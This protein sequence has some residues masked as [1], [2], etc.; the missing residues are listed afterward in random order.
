MSG[1]DSLQRMVLT[2]WMYDRVP[3]VGGGGG[4]RCPPGE[5]DTTPDYDDLATGRGSKSRKG[6]DQSTKNVMT[7][8]LEQ[9]HTCGYCGVG[10]LKL[11]VVCPG[12]GPCAMIRYCS[13]ECLL[14]DTTHQAFVCSNPE[15]VEIFPYHI[16]LRELPS[17]YRRLLPAIP[18]PLNAS[19]AL[20]RQRAFVS[21]LTDATAWLYPLITAH[22]KVHK[23]CTVISRH[24]KKLT[25]ADWAVF[26]EKPTCGSLVHPL[27]VVT[28]PTT[29]GW[30]ACFR[31]LRNAAMYTQDS[32]LVE[33]LA[34]WILDMVLRSAPPA[35]RERWG[36]LFVRQFGR[37]FASCSRGIARLAAPILLEN[38]QRH[39]FI[40]A[41]RWS[42]VETTVAVAETLEPLLYMASKGGML[43]EDQ[44]QALWDRAGPGWTG[45][46]DECSDGSDDEYYGRYPGVRIA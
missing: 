4:L 23:N 10:G 22:Q 38:L 1:W 5:I 24:Q 36:G 17:A 21:T 7:L 26:E 32:S 3:E 46:K 41:D 9:E 18:L 14:V 25:R 40:A 6:K 43:S 33:A 44:L 8:F 27:F 30:G 31:R 39:P 15:H 16:Q 11:G 37:E 19:K 20:F 28:F 12:C 42:L 2:P 34:L 29:D 13:V 45:Q 35:D